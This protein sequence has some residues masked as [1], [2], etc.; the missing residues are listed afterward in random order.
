MNKDGDYALHG[1]KA[2]YVIKSLKDVSAAQ[3]GLKSLEL[4][5]SSLTQRVV[6]KLVANT[7]FSKNAKSKY[8]ARVNNGLEIPLTAIKSGDSYCLHY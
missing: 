5:K 7:P 2:K 4:I 6:S 1:S 8:F 3:T